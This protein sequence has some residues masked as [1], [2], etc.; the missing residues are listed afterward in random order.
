VTGWLGNHERIVKIAGAIDYEIVKPILAIIGSGSNCSDSLAA[1]KETM[2]FEPDPN[3]LT[4]GSS[5][6]VSVTPVR[7]PD[8]A[9][10]DDG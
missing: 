9:S 6:I 10:N 5:L 3:C 7:P 8:F 4:Y 1:G 2:Q